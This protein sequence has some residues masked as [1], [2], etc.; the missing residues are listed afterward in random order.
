VV[1]KSLQNHYAVLTG[2]LHL[3]ALC[4][5]YF[6]T[7]WQI[8]TQSPSQGTPP[9]Q[10][11]PEEDTMETPEY[12]LELLH[13]ESERL[14]HYLH[15]LPP[16]GWNQPSACQCWAVHDVV[17]HLILGAELYIDSVRRGLQG[18]TP[19]LDGWSVAGEA[20]AA[21]AAPLLAQWSIARCQA[22]DGD[23]LQ[24]WHATSVQLQ[25]VL[26]GVRQQAWDTP[27]Y[28]PA[29]VLPAGFCVALR[30]TEVVMHGWDRLCRNFHLRRLAV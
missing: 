15:T 10:Q 4:L 13:M 7:A 24:T 11:A 20:N 1:T 21:S 18:D 16:P 9:A 5:P 29:G 23:V 27:C 12:R 28:H 2:H 25:H 14:D 8:T 30:L 17:G 22:L 3:A 6:L 19:P 26:A